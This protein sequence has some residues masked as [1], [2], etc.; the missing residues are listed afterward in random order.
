[1]FDMK[2]KGYLFQEVFFYVELP[3]YLKKFDKY[4]NVDF[5]GRIIDPHTKQQTK[6]KLI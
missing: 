5:R 1:M 3:Q 4:R 6:L 2:N